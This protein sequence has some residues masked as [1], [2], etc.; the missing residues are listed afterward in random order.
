M[1]IRERFLIEKYEHCTWHTLSY[2]HDRT[3]GKKHFREAVMDHARDR[4]WDI[5]AIR[6]VRQIKTEDDWRDM[7]VLDYREFSDRG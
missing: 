6:L 1:A 5:E 4:Y 7:E 3:I 2:S